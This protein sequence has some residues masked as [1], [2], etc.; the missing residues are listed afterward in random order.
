MV[1]EIQQQVS[2]LPSYG[3]RRAWELLHRAPETQ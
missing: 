2:K 1:V 3:Y